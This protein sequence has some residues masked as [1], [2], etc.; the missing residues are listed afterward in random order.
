VEAAE[1]D[2]WFRE[3]LSSF[4]ACGRCESEPASLLAY[5]GVPL[6][7]STDQ[8][9]VALSTA[10]EVVAMVQRQVDG[11]RAAEYDHSDVLG[12]EISPLNSVSALCA[13]EFSRRR[14]D[15]S[16]IG[17]LTATYFVAGAPDSRRISALAVHSS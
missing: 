6:L 2:R 13:G 14:R 8:G 9:F 10:D 11:M 16:E 3:Y 1:V 15:G 7:L 4:A 5:Y 17:R 12:L